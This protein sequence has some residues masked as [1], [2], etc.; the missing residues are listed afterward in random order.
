VVNTFVKNLLGFL[1]QL[2]WL[3]TFIAAII[4]VFNF[5]RWVVLNDVAAEEFFR[6]FGRYAFAG[7]GDAI[8]WLRDFFQEIFRGEP[9]TTY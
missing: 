2:L 8:Q 6:D 7:V 4:A 9:T 1:I 5:F 3:V